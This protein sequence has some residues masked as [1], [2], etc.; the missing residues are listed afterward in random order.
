MSKKKS[1]IVKVEEIPDKKYYQILGFIII[2]GLFLRFYNLGFNSLW[3]DEAT[4]S[5]ISSKSFG[6]IWQ[7]TLAGEF[8]PPLFYWMEHIMLMLGNNEFILRFL[9][10]LFG[11]LTIPAIYFVGREFE[12]RNVGIIAATAFAVSP[13]LIV[14][15]QEARAYSA[16]LFFITVASIF[17]FRSLSSNDM[18][19]WMAFGTLSAIALWCHFYAIVIFVPYIIYAI[20]FYM[21]DIKSDIKSARWML[22][23]TAAF[24]IISLPIFIAIF[25]LIGL[26]ASTGPAFGFIGL[27]LVIQTF[28]Q[29][30]GFS[31]IVMYLFLM[32][33]AVGVFQAYLMDKSKGLFFVW[34]IMSIFAVSYILSFKIPMVPR[35]LQFMNII[36]FLGIALSYKIFQRVIQ[37]QKVVY[38]FMIMFVLLSAPF[39]T[40]YYGSYS[41]DDWRGFA[42]ILPKITK[43][44]DYIVFVP[45][46]VQTPL[47]YY[48]SNT[49]DKTII[50]G[51]YNSS[52]ME[53]IKKN[54]NEIYYVVTPDIGVA[55]PEG[56]ASMWL[57]ANTQ[58]VSQRGNIYLLRRT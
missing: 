27:P 55:N 33:F 46:Y 6:D 17:Y 8:N 28:S 40:S 26:R 49:T 11:V 19:D 53:D 1:K 30:S 2:V 44:G 25:G 36:F 45:A 47:L 16:M 15:S 22:S 32:L 10:A 20:W 56:D 52:Q 3:L 29:I 4:T 51:A 50:Y 43:D 48:Y 23:G 24:I 37:G 58:S 34:M 57:G 5:M 14:Y 38:C 54:N 18:K 21:G 13:F 12:D 39:I 9:P 35:Y 31:D 42:Q 7:T 41:K